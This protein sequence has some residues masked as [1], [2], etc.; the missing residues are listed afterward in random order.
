MLTK[1]KPICPP[2][3]KQIIWLNCRKGF[4]S[5]KGSA[6]EMVKGNYE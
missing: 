4:M 3:Y 2:C 1:T 5:E 6:I